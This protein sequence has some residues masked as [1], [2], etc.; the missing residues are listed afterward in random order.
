AART[1]RETSVD[2]RLNTL[3]ETV[4]QLLDEVES[5]AISKPIDIKNGARFSD[6]VRQFEVNLIRT[7]LGRTSGSQTLAAKLL[8]LKPTTLNAK[9]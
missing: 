1:S 7:A 2:A 9:I 5:L 3:R 4:L 6:E 8:G